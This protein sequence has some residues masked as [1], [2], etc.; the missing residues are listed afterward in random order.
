MELIRKM[1]QN[2]VRPKRSIHVVFT[3]DEE[4]GGLTGFAPF[5]KTQEFKDLNVGVAIDEGVAKP[6]E[7]YYFYYAER[8]SWCK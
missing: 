4:I 7:E 6:T 5:I 2:N 8:L 3:P 1:K